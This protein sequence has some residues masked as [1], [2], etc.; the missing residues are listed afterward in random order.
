[1]RPPAQP[2]G[3]T[4][5]H[6]QGYAR[7]QQQRQQQSSIQFGDAPSPNRQPQD[8]GSPNRGRD[9]GQVFEEQTQAYRAHLQQQDAYNNG[10]AGKGT[11]ANAYANGSNQNCGNVLT[12][13]RTTRVSAPPGGHSS[14][15]FG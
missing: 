1:M 10:V 12:D 8:Y 5:Q 7:Q 14:I 3:S 4:Q 6:Q 9:R 13:R 15:S 2:L 11:S